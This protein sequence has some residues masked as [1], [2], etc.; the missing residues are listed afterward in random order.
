MMSGDCGVLVV[1]RLDFVVCIWR[2]FVLFNKL[3]EVGSYS[4]GDKRSLSF[5]KSKL[6]AKCSS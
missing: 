4:V 6:D 5:R 2:V 3:S 1:R